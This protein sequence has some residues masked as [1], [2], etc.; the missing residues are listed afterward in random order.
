VRYSETPYTTAIAAATMAALSHWLVP[1][2]PATRNESRL[3]T[4]RAAAARPYRLVATV[5]ANPS[6][7]TPRYRWPCPPGRRRPEQEPAED[8][9]PEHAGAVGCRRC[10][11]LARRPP[12]GHGR[13]HR[14]VGRLDAELGPRRPAPARLQRELAGAFGD[15]RHEQGAAGPRAWRR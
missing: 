2:P 9:Q 15:G 14:P 5:A 4:A 3:S 11:V 1:S 7:R 6:G 10:H 8:E 12:P 13:Q